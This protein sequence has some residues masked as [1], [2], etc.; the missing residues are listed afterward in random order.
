MECP[1]TDKSTG[2]LTTS[3]RRIHPADDDIKNYKDCED[4]PKNSSQWHHWQPPH[5]KIEGIT[6]QCLKKILTAKPSLL[7]PLIKVINVFVALAS[8]CYFFLLSLFLDRCP[9][10]YA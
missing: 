4:K 9:S 2:V 10:G 1:Q 6:I 8:Y 5:G 3:Q 7:G